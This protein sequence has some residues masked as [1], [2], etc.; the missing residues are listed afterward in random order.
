LFNVIVNVTVDPMLAEGWFTFLIKRKSAVCAYAIV[1]AA[2]QKSR[3]CV[4][5]NRENGF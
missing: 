5:T 4:R 1:V 2:K 3:A